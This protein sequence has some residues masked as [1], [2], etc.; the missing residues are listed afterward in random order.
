MVE[1]I[2]KFDENTQKAMNKLQMRILLPLLGLMVLIIVILATI[3]FIDGDIEGG[4]GFLAI[5]VIA[6]L[7]VVGLIFLIKRMTM[8]SNK[9]L[10]MGVTSYFTFDGNYIC[11]KA[12]GMFGYSSINT[13][14]VQ[15]LFRAIETK[16][17]F[18]IYIHSMAA[19]VLP[20][21][22]IVQG[23]KEEL[24]YLLQTWLGSKYKI[25]GRI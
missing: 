13:L 16:E 19:Y 18:F 1:V 20:K 12:D 2:T 3:S 21:K 9:L 23:T 22:D 7:L 4:I 17:N 10:N 15:M 11:L 5:A 24:R 14:P 8:K 6:V 25:R